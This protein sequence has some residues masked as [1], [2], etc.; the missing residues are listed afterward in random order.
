SG[1]F[2]L[3][4]YFAGMAASID[5]VAEQLPAEDAELMRISPDPRRT[6]SDIA[7]KCAAALALAGRH[8]ATLRDVAVRRYDWQSVARR[9]KTE[10]DSLA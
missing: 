5:S 10:L 3:G 1:S 2:P 8:K 7:Q 6:V 9:L 4:T